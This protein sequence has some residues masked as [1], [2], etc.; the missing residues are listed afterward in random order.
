MFGIEGFEGALDLQISMELGNDGTMKLGY[1][2]LNDEEFTAALIDYTEESVYTELEAMG[3]TR[4]Q[5][6]EEM[7]AEFGMTT[8]EYA[9]AAYADLSF[10]SIFQAMSISGVYYVDGGLLYTG[11]VW[12]MELSGSAFTLDGDSLTLA[13][14]LSGLSEE[15]LTF[16]RVTE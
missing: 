11:I 5:I 3:Y 16:S 1:D 4:A 14:E 6:D 10:S 8:R 9:E 15:S 12:D 13:E 2:T 7:V